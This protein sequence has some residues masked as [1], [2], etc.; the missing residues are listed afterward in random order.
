MLARFPVLETKHLRL[1]LPGARAAEAVLEYYLRNQIHLAPWEPRRGPDFFTVAFWAKQLEAAQGEYRRDV[2]TRLILAQK[3][4]PERV[5]G[6]ANL[7]NFVRGSFQACHL[8]YSLDAELQGQG[9]MAE[10]L[11]EVIRFAF[12]DLGLH[13]IMANYQPHNDRSARVLERLGFIRE[14]FA[15]D[16]LYIDGAWR[17]HVLTALVRTGSIF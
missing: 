9:L 1:S 7:S 4:E 5:I 11:K 6:V 15:K 17:D 12:E 10:A 2:G 16:Y 8:G 13:R 14:G 3:S